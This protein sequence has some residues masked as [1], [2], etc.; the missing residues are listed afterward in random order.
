[1]EN[2][3]S[4]PIVSRDDTV[5]EE[6]HGVKVKDPYRY[7]LRIYFENLDIRLTLFHQDLIRLELIN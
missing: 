3:I 1:M 2:K 6:I 4:Y 5:E 7:A